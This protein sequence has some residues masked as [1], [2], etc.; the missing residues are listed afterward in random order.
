MS[1]DDLSPSNEPVSGPGPFFDSRTPNQACRPLALRATESNPSSAGGLCRHATLIAIADDPAEPLS[2][3]A[4]LRAADAPPDHAGAIQ[5]ISGESEAVS[6]LSPEESVP[7]SSPVLIEGLRE[8]H[9][10]RD[11][12]LRTEGNLTRTARSIVA[13][14]VG[15]STFLP[16]EERKEKGKLADAAFDAICAGTEGAEE[17][18]AALA[19]GAHLAARKV[20]TKDLS[21]IERK[22]TKMAKELHVAPFVEA[23]NGFGWIGLAQIVGEAGDLSNYA[24]PGKV[25]KRF[26]LA[27]HAGR[28][29]SE[30]RK[31][32]GLKAEEWEAIG[33]SPKRRSLIFVIGDSLL[34]KQGPY[35]ELYLK[36]KEYEQAK[37]PEL[38]KMAWHRRAQRYM[39]KRL[40]RDLWRAW[41]GRAEEY[42]SDAGLINGDSQVAI[43]ARSDEPSVG[44]IA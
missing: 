28:A 16:T 25:W 39:E 26:G 38:T 27:P 33:Y 41:T 42:S 14:S 24:N 9:R 31:K 7:R 2:D 32:G 12:L 6:I 10:V 34:K 30:W 11:D 36:R 23:T 4:G 19:V 5:S 43:A 44:G 17:M 20:L 15:F 18:V 40:L 13:R 35:R 29:P 3:G 21:V 37:A 8:W 1:D 22:I